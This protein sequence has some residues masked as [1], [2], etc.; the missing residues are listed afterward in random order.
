MEIDPPRSPAGQG[1][2][3]SGPRFLSSPRTHYRKARR[4]PTRGQHRRRELCPPPPQ[5]TAGDCAAQN[6]A[7]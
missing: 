7:E 1:R 5:E 4:R 3:H 6:S 2:G